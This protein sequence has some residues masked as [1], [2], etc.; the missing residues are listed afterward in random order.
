MELFFLG[1]AG[2]VASFA[3]GKVAMDPVARQVSR[4]RIIQEC[5]GLKLILITHEHKEHF[6]RELIEALFE[7]YRPYVIGPKHVLLNL[8]VDSMYKS[9]VAAG[10]TF[11]LS[12]F[13]V[14][15]MRALHPQSKYPVGYVV[16]NS[17]NTIYFAG[18]TYEIDEMYKISGDVAV[19]PIRGMETMGAAQAA[20]MAEKLKFKKVMPVYFADRKDLVEFMLVAKDRAIKPEVGAWVRL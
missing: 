1:E 18:D 8:S 4:E 10:D 13:E 15:V 12:G 14:R 20:R 6:D 5:K 19:L 2:L 3:G 7:K 17:G 16:S 9:D 11:E